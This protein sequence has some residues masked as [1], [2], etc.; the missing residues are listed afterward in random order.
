[1]DNDETVSEQVASADVTSG[2]VLSEEEKDALLLALNP[3]K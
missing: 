2:E 3:V 1:M